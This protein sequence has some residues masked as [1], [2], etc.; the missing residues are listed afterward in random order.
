MS[1]SRDFRSDPPSHQRLAARQAAVVTSEGGRHRSPE[2]D[3]YIMSDRDMRHQRPPSDRRSP[4][5]YYDEEP[6][7]ANNRERRR[8]DRRYSEIRV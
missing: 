7:E 4:H 6:F 8:E 3:R 1:N 2:D 5:R